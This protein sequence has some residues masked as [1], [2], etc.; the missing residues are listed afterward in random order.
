M[1]IWAK[2]VVILGAY[3]YIYKHFK[4]CNEFIIL[5]Y[6]VKEGMYRM[7]VESNS[8]H[9][10][11]RGSWLA[12]IFLIWFVVMLCHVYVYVGIIIISHNRT[13]L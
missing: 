8:L 2:G 3:I 5:W 9:R 4:Y 12:L 10:Y 6:A 7:Y 1:Y 11:G 13:C